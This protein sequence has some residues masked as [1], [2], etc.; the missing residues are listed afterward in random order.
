LS[1]LNSS[2][3]LVP[4]LLLPNPPILTWLMVF[5]SHHRAYHYSFEGFVDSDYPFFFPLPVGSP[6]SPPKGTIFFPVVVCHRLFFPSLRFNKGFFFPPHF[7]RVQIFLS[8][9]NILKGMLVLPPKLFLRLS[10]T[11][12]L[13]SLFR[14]IDAPKLC[15]SFY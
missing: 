10:Y 6:F 15:R 1:L 12:S 13:P 11:G 2:P 4:P 8:F 5:L 9:K 3:H 14:P 7:F